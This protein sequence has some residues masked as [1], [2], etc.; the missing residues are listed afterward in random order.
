MQSGIIRFL[1]NWT[2]PVAICTGIIVYFIFHLIPILQPIAIWY[3][4]YN[5]NVLPDFMFLILFITFC[6]VDFKKL[7]P[8]KW[9]LWISIQQIIFIFAL[10]GIIKYFDITRD[11]LIMLEAILVCIIGPCASAAAVVTAKLGGNLEEMTTYTFIS[12]FIS[13]ILIPFCFPLLP[14]T[15]TEVNL[16]FMPFFLKILWKVSTVLLMPMVFAFI[17]KHSMKRFHHWLINIKDLSYY[18]WGCSLIVVTGTT[19]MNINEAWEHTSVFFLFSIAMMGLILCII[20]FATG[21][22]IG[23]YFDKTVEAG[24][25]LGQK[26]TAFSIWVA[27]AFLNPLSS[28]GPGCYILWQN[29]INSVEI[30]ISRKKGQEQT[31]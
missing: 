27:T 9:H 11:G 2:L 5:A 28:V 22:F 7:L 23:H 20:Q 24:Q 29:I 3:A 17:V 15:G 10:V 6:K 30:W 4:P 1:K 14:Q 25:A 18:M 12:N 26:N 21:R 19:V 16:E 8:V 31:S 13:A